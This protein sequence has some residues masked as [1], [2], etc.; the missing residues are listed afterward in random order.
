MKMSV[1]ATFVFSHW[2][3]TLSTLSSIGLNRPLLNVYPLDL[4]GT[5]AQQATMNLVVLLPSTMKILFGFLSD[6]YPLLGYRRKPYMFL[7]WLAVVLIMCTFY[8]SADLS[9]EYNDIT[10]DAMPPPNA[11]SIEWLGVTFFTFGVGMW[12]ADVM[13]DSI[14]AEKAR[15][16][17]EEN[18]GQLQSTCYA[19]RFFG[20]MTAAPLSTF[21]YSYWGP[22]SVVALLACAP[23]AVLPLIY[24]FAEDSNV[25]IKSTRDQFQEIWTTICSRSVWQPM[26]FVYLFNL[27]QV[28]NAAWKQFLKT[29]L[30]FTAVQLNSL[31]VVSYIALFVGTMIYKLFFLQ[32]SWRRI[33]QVCIVVNA[34]FTCL[35]L[36]LITGNTM[37]ISPYWFTLGDDAAAEFI[38]GFQFLVRF[39]QVSLD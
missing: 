29:V 20:I 14:V 15:L 8:M 39:V 24:F 3:Q 37:G 12:L 5:E 13:G 18:K 26:G 4:G 32:A 1:L 22:R 30:H 10:G 28:Q 35:Q 11:P 34:F 36:L 7:G 33:Y 19:C 17:T 6:N 23:L 25:P 21:C 16:E 27:L 31:L 9:I 38:A 2:L